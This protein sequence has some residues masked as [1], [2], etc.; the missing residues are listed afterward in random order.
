MVCVG[1]NLILV[2]FPV[3]IPC[4]P[5]SWAS[6]CETKNGLSPVIQNTIEV[7]FAE[8][9]YARRESTYQKLLQ[10]F[11]VYLDKLNKKVLEYFDNSWFKCYL[12]WSNVGRATW[13][14]CGNFTTNRVESNWTQVKA[15]IGAKTGIDRCISAI[16]HHQIS[17]F[18]GF[19]A[20]LSRVTASS[21]TYVG[22][23]G[24]LRAIASVL[25]NFALDKVLRQ[26]E[27]YLANK[28]AWRA[29]SS[30]SSSPIMV[31]LPKSLAMH[32]SSKIDQ[33]EVRTASSSYYVDIKKWSCTCFNAVTMRLPCQHMV[34]V[35][36][37]VLHHRMLP[38]AAIHNRWN[39]LSATSILA[40]LLSIVNRLS[41]IRYCTVGTHDDDQDVSQSETTNTVHVNPG[42]IKYLQV[43]RHQKS[44]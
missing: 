26:W 4:Y 39:M 36:A 9:M 6:Y 40:V 20:V 34:Y 22:V 38:T 30:S 13:F 10:P 15:V 33:Y 24:S 7:R 31:L 28:S 27:Y 23:P 44:N 32:L 16:F 8:V 2:D 42:H 11:R 1:I 29:V 12:H 37:D 14:S 21:R 25:S 41:T 35:S 3:P 19:E 18:R 17:I 5:C 43:R